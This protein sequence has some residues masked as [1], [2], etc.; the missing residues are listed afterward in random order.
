MNLKEIVKGANCWNRFDNKLMYRQ[1]SDQLDY[2][3][4][5]IQ[6]YCLCDAYTCRFYNAKTNSCDAPVKRRQEIFDLD[7]YKK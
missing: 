5:Q 7:R 6:A 1:Q 3:N 2:I 4:K